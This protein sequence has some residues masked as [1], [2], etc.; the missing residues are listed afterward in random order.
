MAVFDDTSLNISGDRL[1]DQGKIVAALSEYRKG[2]RLNPEN[3]NLRN[4]LGVCF[5]EQGNLES[6]IQRI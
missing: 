4:S 3:N 2:L 5:G 1:F 6:A